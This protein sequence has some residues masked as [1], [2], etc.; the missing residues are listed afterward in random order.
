MKKILFIICLLGISFL[1]AQKKEKYDLK[2]LKYNLSSEQVVK[3]WGEPD[4]ILDNYLLE[5][6]YKDIDYTIYINF[7][8]DNKLSHV[9][10]LKPGEKSINTYLPFKHSYF[11]KSKKK[12]KFML[13]GYK[14]EQ[15]LLQRNYEQKYLHFS[16]WIHEDILL[17]NKNISLKDKNLY[18]YAFREDRVVYSFY[19]YEG[20]TNNTVLA[21]IIA[22]NY[23]TYKEVSGTEVGFIRYDKNDDGI[24]D[25]YEGDWFHNQYYLEIEPDKEYKKKFINFD[26]N[27]DGIVKTEEGLFVSY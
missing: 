22:D 12:G 1:Y 25:E 24:I 2:K 20:E 21:H 18:Y 16:Q 9:Y 23:L 11:E 7:F 3:L 17:R 14:T 19:V 27:E 15:D 10:I 8:T 26:M 5:F 6:G 4:E 13:S